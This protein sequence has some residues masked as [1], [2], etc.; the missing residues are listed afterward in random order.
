LRL[1]QSSSG[2]ARNRS[3][4]ERTPVHVLLAYVATVMVIHVGGHLHEVMRD[5]AP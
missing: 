2:Q 3:E 1:R 5:R 4:K